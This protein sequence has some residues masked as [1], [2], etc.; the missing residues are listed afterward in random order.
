MAGQAA[1][2]LKPDQELV[3]IAAYLC[4]YEVDNPAAVACARRCFIDTLACLLEAL[5][6]PDC[7]RHMGPVV[8]GATLTGGARVPGTPY[9]LDPVTATFNI[10]IALRWLDMSDGFVAVQGSHPSD[11]LAGILATADYLSRQRI[12]AGKP[13]LVVADVLRALV[14][15]YEIQG[16]LSLAN[17]FN[18]S[19]LD[20]VILT[21][22]ATAGG[23]ARML[24]GG[25]EAVL[26]AV[27]NAWMDPGLRI[28][29]QD[30]GTGPRKGWAAADASTHGVR[31]AIMAVKGEPAYPQV[32]SANKWGFYD[33]YRKGRPF[34]FQ[35]P[36]GDYVIQNAILKFVAACMHAQTAVECALILHPQ[37]RDRLHDIERIEIFC[38]QASMELID[39]SGPLRH[40]ADRDHCVQYIVAVGLIFGRMAPADYEDALAADPRIDALRATMTAAE[41]PAFTAGYNDPAR[42]SSP[43]GVQVF[44]RDGSTTGRV[45]VEYPAGHPKRREETQALFRRKFV[46]AV[47]RRFAGEQ[48][49]RILAACEDAQVL[50]A[51]PVNEFMALF[52]A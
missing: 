4:D 26:S 48:A 30:P 24:G 22:V 31:L 19:S 16:G 28:H 20:H 6:Y 14:K 5:A 49:G 23:V 12:A 17:N 47:G 42:R 15:A 21:K 51:L 27:S 32:L 52:C 29:R 44:F 8:P 2:A 33:V 40:A 37:V 13:P 43:N 11:N 3:D 46:D 36:Y 7:T 39:K 35:R 1:A 41:D 18:A 9:E 25:F 10:G 34:E 50:D 38:H 45:D